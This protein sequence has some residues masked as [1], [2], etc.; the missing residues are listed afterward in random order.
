MDRSGRELPEK[1]AE[2]VSSERG[3]RVESEEWDCCGKASRSRE[4]EEKSVDR[5]GRARLLPEKMTEAVYPE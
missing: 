2:A 5:R 3:L 1:Q 4:F